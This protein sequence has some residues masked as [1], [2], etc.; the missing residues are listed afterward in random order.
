MCNGLIKCQSMGD[1]CVWACF[2]N[3]KLGYI[4][5]TNIG[6]ELCWANTHTH[7][8]QNVILHTDIGSRTQHNLK[9]FLGD[10]I[11]V[12]ATCD[13]NVFVTYLWNSTTNNAMTPKREQSSSSSICYCC[14]EGNT[15]FRPTKP[16]RYNSR[17]ER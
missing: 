13:V 12:F 7:I 15:V 17:I 1:N 2:H 4:D 8:K 9:R 6:W 3:I 16:N 10:S 5:Q 14:P 11:L